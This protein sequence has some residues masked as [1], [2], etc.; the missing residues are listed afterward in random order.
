M[1][2]LTIN[3]TF[4]TPEE[5]AT[6]LEEIARLISNGYKS[7]YVPSWSLDKIKEPVEN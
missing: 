5:T 7:G 2:E 6:A 3:N 4:D 1:Y